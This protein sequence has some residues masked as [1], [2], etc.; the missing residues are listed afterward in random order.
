[1][2]VSRASCGGPART[3]RSSCF[4]APGRNHKRARISKPDGQTDAYRTSLKYLVAPALRHDHMRALISKLDGRTLRSGRVERGPRC[5]CR[6]CA[7]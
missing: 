3:R 7:T 2:D 4:C 1:M 6:P 5:Y